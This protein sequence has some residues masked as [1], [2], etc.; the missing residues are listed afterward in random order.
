MGRCGGGAT[1]GRIPTRKGTGMSFLLHT[2]V[3]FPQFTFQ[4]KKGK[5]LETG[6]TLCQRVGP[7]RLKAQQQSG[8]IDSDCV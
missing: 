3:P 4:R 7:T 1:M 6:L 5:I 2:I 8:L